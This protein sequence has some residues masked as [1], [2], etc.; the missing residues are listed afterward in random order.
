MAYERRTWS[1][2]F[3]TLS[4]A[5]RQAP[6]PAEDLERLATSAYMLG[7]NEDSMSTL[8][9]AH[10]G[11]L[12]A[13]EPLRAASCA[14]WIGMHH[15]VAGEHGLGGGWLARAQRLI[16]REGGE[17]AEQGYMLLAAAFREEASG[18]NAAAAALAGQAATIG[19]RFGDADLF[20]LSLMDQGTCLILAGS[21][22]EGLRLLD[23]AMVAVTVGE[24]SPIPNGLVYCGLIL[25][26][27][28][29]YDVSRAQQWTRVM[30]T[31][32]DEQPDIVA[33]TGTCRL[34]RAELMQ[35]R[36]AW[37]D[38]LEEA[39]RARRRSEQGH[40]PHSAGAAAY[41]RGEVHRLQG[42]FE[43][44]EASYRDASRLGWEPQPGLALLWLARGDADAAAAALRRVLAEGLDPL[45][46]ARLLPAY[47]EVMLAIGDIEA[48]RA[49]L[50]TLE[51]I[52]AGH[53]AAMLA[54]IVGQ[55]RA[56]VELAASD[57]RAAVVGARRALAIWQDIGAPHDAARAR[58][59]IALA[60][61]A[62]GDDHTAALELEAARE[63]FVQLGAAPDLERVDALMRPRPGK[64][65]DPGS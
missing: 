22:D 7:R 30:T 14:F 38:A 40:N 3:E 48:A 52:A 34:H 58:V 44:A 8:E 43:T 6:L 5:D 60:C 62:L 63:V 42:D 36:G 53:E 15:F 4:V 23:E 54:A 17:C 20:A 21:V 19:E 41:L 25:G 24:L 11:Y 35:L 47:V 27:Q 56:A 18:N 59:T 12:E 9:R 2:A 51:E 29:A 31:W 37:P 13:G 57:A 33:F 39:E 64:P 55:T 32:C 46:A 49:A 65:E 61:R 26:C 50:G 1:E 45:R 16:E 10:H 28:Q